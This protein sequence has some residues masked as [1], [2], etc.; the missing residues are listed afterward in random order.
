[1]DKSSLA[2]NLSRSCSFGGFRVA[3]IMGRPTI[4]YVAGG[5]LYT[6]GPEGEA[7]LV[8]STFIQTILD[9]V[10]KNRERHEWKSGN[11]AWQVS[12]GMNPL[13]LK[14][15]VAELRRVHY[16]GVAAGSSANEVLYTI[17]TDYTC[18]LFHQELKDGYERRIYHRNQF[19]ASDLSRCAE[20]GTMAFAVRSPDGTARIATIAAE[21]RGL[22][23]ITEGDAVDEAPYWA[24]GAKNV[25]LFQSAGVGRDQRGAYTGLSPYAICKIDLEKNKME[26]LVEEEQ[27]DALSPKQTKDG[28]LYFIRRPYQPLGKPVSIFRMALDVILF[29]FRLLMAI[30]A[31]LNVFSLMFNKKPLITAGG[32][33]R[34][35]PDQRILMLY[36]R[37]IDAR[38]IKQ[39]AAN[40]NSPAL[41]PP[42]WELVGKKPD[43]V[44]SVLAKNVL[45]YDLCPDGGFV[46]TNGSRIYYVSASGESAE[47]GK[48]DLIERVAVL[49]I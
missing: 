33:E 41:V 21:G 18:G 47:I 39:S 17:D 30:V 49:G 37:L 9:R 31:F 38:K 5:R 1:M 27:C 25:I 11:M 2:D 3:K 10:E 32:P 48:G 22:K 36:G 19:R 4:A 45:A 7:R 6:Q 14:G 15:N 16:T 8:E 28:S 42:S 46:Y 23:E 20:T 13:G 26:M 43:G 44:E 35:G 34:E 40:G 24:P 12:R 29:P